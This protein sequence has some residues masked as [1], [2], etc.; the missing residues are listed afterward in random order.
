MNDSGLPADA[1]YAQ[2]MDDLTS[3]T[4]PHGKWGLIAA[5]IL[6]AGLLGFFLLQVLA[7]T[8]VQVPRESRAPLVQVVPLMVENRPVPVRG[9]G[10]VRPRAQVTV[11]AQVSGEV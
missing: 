4:E 1:S 9:D 6:A 3:G 2:R 7:S 5:G 8:P 11:I 10:P